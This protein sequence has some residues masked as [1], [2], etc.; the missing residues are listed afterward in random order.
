MAVSFAKSNFRQAAHLGLCL[1]RTR[2]VLSGVLELRMPKPDARRQ[3]LDVFRLNALRRRLRV[4]SPPPL[5]A[6]LHAAEVIPDLQAS[7][8]VLSPHG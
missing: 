8:V 3:L 2:M 4:H 6:R 5:I 1:P 7:Q